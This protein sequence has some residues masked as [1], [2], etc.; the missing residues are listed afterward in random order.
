VLCRCQRG[1]RVAAASCL[2]PASSCTTST[3]LCALQ[4]LR[5]TAWRRYHTSLLFFTCCYKSSCALR[6]DIDFNPQRLRSNHI[7]ITQPHHRS[8]HIEQLDSRPC[9]SHNIASHFLAFRSLPGA[10]IF[11]R[12]PCNTHFSLYIFAAAAFLHLIPH[13]PR[14]ASST[15][16]GIHT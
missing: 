8:S 9:N 2:V 5:H 12:T 10:F 7:A 15:S 13:P 1:Y 14:S 6:H 4:S 11:D 16:T 3:F